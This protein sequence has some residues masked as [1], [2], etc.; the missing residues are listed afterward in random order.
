MPSTQKTHD[1]CCMNSWVKRN[2]VANLYLVFNNTEGRMG[3]QSPG[4]RVRVLH[5]LTSTLCKCEF[6]ED[7]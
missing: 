5:V 7:F 4:V 1:V 6:C 2:V 3:Q